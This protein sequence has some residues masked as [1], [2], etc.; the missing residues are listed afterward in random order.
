MILPSASPLNG[1]N[2]HLGQAETCPSEFHL[3]HSHSEKHVKVHVTEI[4]SEYT[5]YFFVLRS[6]CNTFC[7]I[8]TVCAAK[9]STILFS[10]GQI[11]SL[12][13][14]NVFTVDISFSHITS[15]VKYLAFAYSLW[16][17]HPNLNFIKMW[18][19]GTAIM[20]TNGF[21]CLPVSTL[22]K[23]TR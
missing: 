20:V 12:N 14:R 5:L 6:L 3:Q 22:R 18:P 7:S 21:H 4:A 17:C 15:S 2:G 19:G 8:F 9:A 16:I 11:A 1:C 23:V 13:L 10:R